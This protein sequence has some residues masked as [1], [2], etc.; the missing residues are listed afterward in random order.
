MAKRGRKVAGSPTLSFL[1]R[2]FPNPPAGTSKNAR[3]TWHRIVRAFPPDHF[4]PYQYDLLRVYCEEAA[5]YRKAV[6][7]LR[8]GGEVI[9]SPTGIA[10]INPWAEIAN[11]SAKSLTS[12]CTK[13]GLNINSTLANRGKAPETPR[14]KSKRDGLL[15]GGKNPKRT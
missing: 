8:K 13:L 2:P 6:L 15:F 10:K 5:L 3:T 12:L 1:E 14:P 7:E 4:K 9:T 11:K